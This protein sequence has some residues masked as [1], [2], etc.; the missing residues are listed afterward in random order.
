[1]PQWLRHLCDGEHVGFAGM[2]RLPFMAFAC[3]V[4]LALGGCGGDGGGG[5]SDSDQIK[6]AIN[7]AYGA[8]AEEDAKTFCSHLTADY[9]ADFEDYYGP[10]ED[11]TLI[12]VVSD[13]DETERKMLEDPQI[14]ALH[15]DKKDKSAY[16][17][18]NGDGLEMEQEGGKWKLDDFDVPGS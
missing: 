2:R 18:V 7:D 1:M 14:G 5:G 16:P 12:E 11:S 17:D 8:F 13:L 6:S 9:K 15:I 10:C 3:A 4:A